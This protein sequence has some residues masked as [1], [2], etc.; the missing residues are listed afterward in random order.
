MTR[1]SQFSKVIEAIAA[2][3]RRLPPTTSPT[4]IGGYDELVAQMVKILNSTWF[5]RRWANSPA[6]LVKTVTIRTMQTNTYCEPHVTAL[7][8]RANAKRRPYDVEFRVAPGQINLVQLL[9][10][11]THFIRPDWN[12][13]A[14]FCREYLNIVG[15]FMGADAKKI[16]TA[17]FQARK[18]KNRVYSDEAR[19][20][21]RHRYLARDLVP[22]LVALR[23]E[24]AGN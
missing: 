23:D 24:L 16:V 1:D 11:A 22:D 19:A 15:R 9:H 7:K 8:Q 21:A 12:H 10:I 13:D 3:G 18:I 4:T 17:E 20:A 2:A 5:Q 14:A 6:P